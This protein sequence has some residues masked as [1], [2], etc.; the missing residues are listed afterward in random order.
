MRL[1]VDRSFTIRGA[2]TVVTG[3]LPAGPSGT[4]RSC[5]SARGRAVRV[6]G[7]EALGEPADAVTGVARVALNLRGIPADLPARGMAL[8]E[9][10]QWTITSEI[11]VRVTPPAA[12]RS[13]GSPPTS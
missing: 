10:G 9:P 7:L 8:I 6:R 11:D 5:C 1:W 3:T 13:R 2:G 12:T 4:A